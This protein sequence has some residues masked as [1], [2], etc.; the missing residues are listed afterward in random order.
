MWNKKE[1]RN[2]ILLSSGHP[3][4]KS[5]LRRIGSIPFSFFFKFLR[6]RIKDGRVYYMLLQILWYKS[7]CVYLSHTKF[8]IKAK[9]LILF[10][11]GRHAPHHRF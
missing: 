4:P 7:I 2:R 1:M 10:L 8:R 11:Y 9:I 6:K 5:R 3:F